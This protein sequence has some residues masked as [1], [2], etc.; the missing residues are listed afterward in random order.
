MTSLQPDPRDDS[1]RL[2]K[3]GE[4]PCLREVNAQRPLAIH[5]FTTTKRRLDDL[6]MVRQADNA[7]DDVDIRRSRQLLDIVVAGH[8]VGFGRRRRRLRATGA[9]RRQRDPIKAAQR[10]KMRHRSPPAAGCIRAH[11]AYP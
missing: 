1:L 11:Q 7:A 8:P 10:G 4:R 3:L 6:A 5:V 9:N 2:G